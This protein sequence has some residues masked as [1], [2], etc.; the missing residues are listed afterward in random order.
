MYL[1][2][3]HLYFLFQQRIE[4]VQML[5]SVISDDLTCEICFNI[6]F[7]MGFYSVSVEIKKIK[8]LIKIALR[9]PR[10]EIDF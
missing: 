8:S 3:L 9:Q 4:N 5:H 1:G 7:N 6:D 10:M 2:C